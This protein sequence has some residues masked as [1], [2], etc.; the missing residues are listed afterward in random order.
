MNEAWKRFLTLYIIQF[1]QLLDFISIAPSGALF[2]TQHQIRSS[3]ISWSLSVYSVTAIFGSFALSSQWFKSFHFSTKKTLILLLSLFVFSQLI[4][5]VSVGDLTFIFSRLLGGLTGGLMGSIAYSQLKNISDHDHGIWNGRIQTAQSM[6]ALVGLPVCLFVISQIGSRGYFVL[7]S[8]FTLSIIYYLTQTQFLSQS[9]SQ[10]TKE[11]QSQRQASPLNFKLFIHHS[12]IVVTG[13]LCF[14]SSYLFM[15]QL[16]NYLLNARQVSPSALSTAYSISGILT[17]LLSG[18]IGKLSKPLTAY[19][20]LMVFAFLLIGVQWGFNASS[21]SLIVYLGLPLYLVL[22]TGRAIHQRGIVLQKNNDDSVQMH[23]INNISIRTGILISGVLLAWIAA[24]SDH[25]IQKTFKIA[26][27]VSM[28]CS[29]L[30][31]IAIVFFAHKT[32]TLVTSKE[33]KSN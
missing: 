5:A 14:L 22:S 27:A 25:D 9:L 18:S 7:T 8:V 28:A 20:W 16:P 33:I 31:M 29:L 30:T 32:K 11:E 4:L 24:K 13:F 2:V 15:S 21:I 3:T 12:D 19:G 17:L 10:S 1:L 26:N 6:V 23:L